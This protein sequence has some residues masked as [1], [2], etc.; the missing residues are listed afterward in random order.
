M[1]TI[2]SYTAHKLQ[3]CLAALE[4][5]GF[6]TALA[7]TPYEAGEIVFDSMVPAIR[8]RLV[9]WGDSMTLHATGVIDRFRTMEGIELIDTFEEGVPREEI[10]ER[11]RQALLCDLFLT[12]SNAVT[13]DGKLVNLD[14]VGNRIGGITFGPHHVII[15]VGIN[16]IVGDVEAAIDRVKGLAAPMNAI[17]HQDFNTP[18]RK[19]GCCME[20]SNPQR[21]CNTWSIIEKS[22]P[23]KRIKVIIIE[24]DL[25]L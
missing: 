22:Y 12:G 14:M 5:N 1:K 6:G 15:M 3:R 21:I 2:Y 17:R 18:C 4:E 16:K 19:T 23:P 25:G 10:I 11:R 7:A 24:S 8:P 13:E 20:C 9:S